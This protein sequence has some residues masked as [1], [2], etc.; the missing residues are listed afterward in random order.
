MIF[1]FLG[2][3]GLIG[4][5]YI[6]RRR[7]WIREMS[8]GDF[9]IAALSRYDQPGLDRDVNLFLALCSNTEKEQQK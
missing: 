6:R 7:V 8:Q 5:L 3:L 4:G 9:E 2:L 1:A